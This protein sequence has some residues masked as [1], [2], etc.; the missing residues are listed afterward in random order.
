MVIALDGIPTDL[1]PYGILVACI[2][3]FALGLAKAIDWLD[4]RSKAQNDANAAGFQLEINGLKAEVVELRGE[5]ATLRDGQF[6]SRL[7]LIEIISTTLEPKTKELA[8]EA[9]NLL[10]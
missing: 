2:I 6:Q 10:H 4:K 9:A 5:I 3:V 1:G 8:K 7:K